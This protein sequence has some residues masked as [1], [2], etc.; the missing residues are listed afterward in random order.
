MSHLPIILWN[1]QRHTSQA[2]DE[3]GISIKKSVLSPPVHPAPYAL[4]P[5]S[6]TFKKVPPLA[7]FCIK[8]LSA[9]PDQLHNIGHMRIQNNPEVIQALIL[10]GLYIAHDENTKVAYPRLDTADPRLWATLV[11]VMHHSS[12]DLRNFDIPLADPHLPLLQRIPATPYFSLVTLLSLAGCKELCDETISVLRRLNNLTA[13]D[14]RGTAISSYGVTVLARGLCWDEDEIPARRTGPWGLRVLRLHSCRAIDNKVYS[15]LDKLPLLSV[16]DLRNTCCTVGGA[17]HSFI[18]SGFR[19]SS[20]PALFHPRPL[21]D[22]VE[23]LEDLSQTHQPPVSLYSSSAESAFKVHIEELFHPA[24]PNWRMEKASKSA[25]A[26]GDT[27]VVV[28]A[29]SKVERNAKNVTAE[30]NHARRIKVFEVRPSLP[31]P[32]NVK[33]YALELERKAYNDDAFGYDYGSEQEDFYDYQSE[34][35][36]GRFAHSSDDEHSTN[37]DENST[38]EDEPSTDEDEVIMHPDLVAGTPEAQPAISV[39]ANPESNVI[40]ESDNNVPIAITPVPSAR[41]LHAPEP[42]EVLD[43]AFGDNLAPRCLSDLPPLPRRP[44]VRSAQH[45][46]RF[47][48]SISHELGGRATPDPFALARPSPSWSILE[49]LRP[50]SSSLHGQGRALAASIE[51]K[52]SDSLSVSTPMHT[53]RARLKQRD[54]Q[55]VRALID[56]MANKVPGAQKAAVRPADRFRE[57][58]KGHKNPFVKPPNA[59]T[60]SGIS[61]KAIISQK[62]PRASSSS[63][64]ISNTPITPATPS[65]HPSKSSSDTKA[66]PKKTSE[67]CKSLKPIT[68]MPTPI[69]PPEHLPK[70]SVPKPLQPKVLRQARLSFPG[71]EAPKDATIS[72]TPTKKRPLESRNTGKNSKRRMSDNGA[73]SWNGKGDS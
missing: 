54:A 18:K 58:D 47:D 1:P 61:K 32:P 33:K 44:R 52:N 15:S 56:Q 42:M 55:A 40:Q 51:A 14:L 19:P 5:P 13:L 34:Y 6:I 48:T 23:C 67:S 27:I 64:F 59:I 24:P 20:T 50:S 43:L 71:T 26:T 31:I 10:H 3:G 16:I 68:T 63:S 65:N 21:H 72:N 53:N 36:S 17:Y 30:N 62:I 37:E 8:T 28:P 41:N 69:L 25:Q 22:A 45:N 35:S 60:R 39:V 2:T 11:Q 29:L 7:Y 4:D 66:N 70:P 12:Y 38:D 9:Y 57:R 73:F 49:N 46:T